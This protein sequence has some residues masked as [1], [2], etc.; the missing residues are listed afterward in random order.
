M[1]KSEHINLWSAM[2]SLEGRDLSASDAAEK[3]VKMADTTCGFASELSLEV[4]E[5]GTWRVR[6]FRHD[7]IDSVELVLSPHGNVVVTRE[8]SWSSGVTEKRSINIE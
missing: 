6:L 2:T 5:H 8:K 3:V 4:D 1:T 7:D